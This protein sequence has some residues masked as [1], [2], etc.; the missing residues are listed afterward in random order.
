MFYLFTYFFSRCVQYL[1][2]K[3]RTAG[4]GTFWGEG[5][6]ETLFG[7]EAVYVAMLIVK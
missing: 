3:K 1:T 2:I 4:K 5:D 7:T 6:T